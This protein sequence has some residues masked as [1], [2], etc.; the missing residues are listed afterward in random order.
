VLCRFSVPYSMELVG[1]QGLTLTQCVTAVN[2]LGSDLERFLTILTVS[3]LT[4]HIHLHADWARNICPYGAN[5][6]VG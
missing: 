5:R 6:W 3:V 1:F 2:F 4:T